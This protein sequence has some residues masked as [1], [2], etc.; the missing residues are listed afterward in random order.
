M[1][2]RR[3][4][5][6]LKYGGLA[7]GGG[8]LATGAGVAAEDG[9]D[10]DVASGTAGEAD[11][12]S[13]LGSNAGND[14]VVP[15][16]AA[17]EPPV[18]VAWEYDHGGPVA[19]VDGRVYLTAGGEVHA[20][21][22]ADG[23][24]AW[25]THDIGAR[26]VPAVTE[27]AVVVGGERLTVMEREDGEI[28]CQSDLGYDE[29]IPSPVVADGVA[30][31]VADGV[32]HAVALDTEEPQ[33][34]F[35]PDGDPL[36]EQPVAVTDDTVVAASESVLFALA[37]EDGTVRWSDSDP[38]GDDEYARFAPPTDRQVSYPVADDGVV[39]VGSVDSEPDAMWSRGHV[40]R[41]DV[42]T[43]EKR[44]TS[45]RGPTTP[46]PIMGRRF[47]ARDSHSVAGYGRDG[48]REWEPEVH[49]YRTATPAIGGDTVYVGLEI[50]GMAYDPGEAPSPT[51]GVYAFDGDGT[52]QWAVDTGEVPDIALEDGTL[53]AGGERLVAIRAEG[54]D[55]GGADGD[56]EGDDSDASAD[57]V[58]TADAAS[59]DEANVSEKSESSDEPRH[60]VADSSSEEENDGPVDSVPGFTAGAGIAGGVAALGW[61]RRKTDADD[62]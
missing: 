43:G 13:S 35:E 56:H 37:L 54:D 15:A 52:V 34:S 46:G 10:T 25:Q 20:L 14:P 5:D 1:I 30:V 32:C 23:S 38:A 53:Y 26:G 49:T 59:D 47:Y 6:F 11:G 61:L 39:A 55:R 45:E 19:V 22:A 9:D 28:C 62:A 3:R 44:T 36:F 29:A 57:A 48:D 21:E 50:D 27:D 40:T 8:L 58:S 24:L 4:R 12:W 2:E 33:W 42:E 60:Q 7:V 31:V 51:R 18:T 16:A 17:P 41:Y